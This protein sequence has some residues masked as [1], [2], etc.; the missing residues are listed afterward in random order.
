MAHKRRKRGETLVE[1]LFAI[2]IMALMSVLFF[3]S[4]VSSQKINEKVS[5]AD[6]K[7]QSEISVAEKGDG[8]RS[9]SVTV[10]TGGESFKY[11]VVF[12]GDSGALVSYRPQEADDAK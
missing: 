2:L 5:K 10:T 8:N 9:G 7:L 4:A 11:D 6:K 3:T 1:T 12:S